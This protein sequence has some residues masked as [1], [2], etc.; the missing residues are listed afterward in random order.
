M[1]GRESRAARRTRKRKQ[2]KKLRTPL[3]DRFLLARGSHNHRQWM[4]MVSDKGIAD[5]REN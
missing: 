3:S 5:F 2:T 4:G 1:E